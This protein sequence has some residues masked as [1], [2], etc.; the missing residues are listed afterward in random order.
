MQLQI[1]EKSE[2]LT[3]GIEQLTVSPMRFLMMP[4]YNVGMEKGGGVE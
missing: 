3:D 1:S 2:T 4:F